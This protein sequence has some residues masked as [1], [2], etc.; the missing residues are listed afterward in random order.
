MSNFSRNST[1]TLASLT[2]HQSSELYYLAATFIA[3][4]REDSV[5]VRNNTVASGDAKIIV[6]FLE[7]SDI[8]NTQLTSGLFF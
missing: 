1:H 7:K 3:Q 4:T 6:G 2:Q 5:A 8:W